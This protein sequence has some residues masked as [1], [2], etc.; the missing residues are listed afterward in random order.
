MR[1]I[2]VV[3]VLLQVFSHAEELN[4]NKIRE[5]IESSPEANEPQN[6]NL[7]N[8]LKN[9]KSP[10][11]FK[12][13]N[14]TNIT[15]SQTDQNEAKV[16][17]REYVLHIDNK[18]L[19]F[20]KLRISEKEIQDAIA[21]YRNQELSLQN[22]KDITN[23]IAYYCQ[24]SGYPSATAYI[25]PQ[26]LS[27]NKVQINI[28]F[29]TLGKVIIKNNSGVRDYALESKLNKNL[30]GKVITT[31]NVENEI[32]K[33]FYLQDSDENQI[34]YGINYSTFIGNL[35]ITPFATQGHYVLGGIY[36]N[37]GFYG[38]SMNV[39]VNFSYPVFLYT[40]YS[41]YLVSGFTHK[42][43]KDYYLDGL[44]SN[45]KTSNSVNLGIEGT[46]KGLENNVLSYTLNFTYGNVEND[47]D[48]SG[49]NGVNLGNFGKMNLN[50]SNEYQFQERLTHIFQLNYQ[51]VVGGAV[52]DS[53]ESVSLGGPYGVRAYLEGEGSADN[54]VSGTLGIRFQTPLEG[55]YLTPFYDIGYSWY[56]NKEY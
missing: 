1:K 11:N 27:S 45:E 36:R 35:K 43:I 37:L 20:K 34:D 51:K 50:L 42:K 38:D 3:L 55:L 54:V 26:D 15:N 12:E 16:F 4:N 29:G 44:V 2:L 33:N 17:V 32:Y 5:L 14:T 9:Q 41:L 49:F 40:E 6:K 31:K 48:S 56:E 22:L 39:G 7:K 28:A 46:Y 18:D 47:G 24:V 25:P 21:E 10:V 23:I 8:T 19:T 52:L 13:Q 53:S 30:K